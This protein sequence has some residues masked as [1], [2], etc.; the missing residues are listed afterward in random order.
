MLSVSIVDVSVH[1]IVT[2]ETNT[3]QQARGVCTPGNNHDNKELSIC[4]N[5]SQVI[6]KNAKKIS[7]GQIS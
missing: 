3:E 6:F 4:D 5:F 7:V 1:D 2:L